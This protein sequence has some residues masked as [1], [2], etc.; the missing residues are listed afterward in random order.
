MNDEGEETD[1]DLATGDGIFFQG[2]R[3]YHHVKAQ[4]DPTT[5]RYIVGWQ[6]CSDPSFVEPK[7]LCSEL[8]GASSKETLSI[9]GPVVLGALL[10]NNVF[11]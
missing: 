2:T 6:Y 11:R 8:R 3:T 10:T 4:T 1:H 9:M 7:T 5:I